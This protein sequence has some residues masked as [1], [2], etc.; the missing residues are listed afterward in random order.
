M[1]GLEKELSE[2][3]KLTETRANRISEQDLE[4]KFLKDQVML[5]SDQVLKFKA[6]SDILRSGSA[7]DGAKLLALKEEI[8]ALEEENQCLKNQ[9]FSDS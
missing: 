6:L 4:I 1:S 7:R 9:C 2:Q 8:R 5:Q 3:T